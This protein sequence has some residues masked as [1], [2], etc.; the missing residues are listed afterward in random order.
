[1]LIGELEKIEDLT[2]FV[3]FYKGVLAGQDS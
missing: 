3:G 2:S 1:V